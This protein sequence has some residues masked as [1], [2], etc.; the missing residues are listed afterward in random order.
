MASPVLEIAGDGVDVLIVPGI[1]AAQ[2]AASLLGSPLG[3]DHCSISLSDLLTPWEVIQGRVKAA[4][5]GDLSSHSTTRARKA[6]PG[7]L[8]R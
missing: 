3:H 6:A 4:A 5:E 8:V 2:A 7:S 1:T